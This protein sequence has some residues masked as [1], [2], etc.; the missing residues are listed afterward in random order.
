MCG[1]FI[2]GRP[3][4]YVGLWR[5]LCRQFRSLWIVDL[6]CVTTIRSGAFWF[7]AA[8]PPA[9]RRLLAEPHCRCYVRRA[10][11]LD[12]HPPVRHARC[13]SCNC[14]VLARSHVGTLLVCSRLGSRRSLVLDDPTT[15]RVCFHG[16]RGV[17]YQRT[18]CDWVAPRNTYL[19]CGWTANRYLPLEFPEDRS[20]RRL[21]GFPER[22]DPT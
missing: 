15:G 14:D 6:E 20:L 16:D 11:L 7:L 13:C 1:G 2:V 9:R 3:P 17:S 8:G 10:P 12:P 22:R 18:F 5:T 21:R 4:R 19:R